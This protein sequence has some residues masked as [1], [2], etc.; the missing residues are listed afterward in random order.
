MAEEF[1]PYKA[2]GQPTQAQPKAPT[3]EFDPYKAY[4]KPS[5]EQKPAAQ[6]P[7]DTWED[8]KKSGIAG[9]IRGTAAL[10]GTPGDIAAGT[11]WL[12]EEARHRAIQSGEEKGYVPQGSAQEYRTQIEKER[13]APERSY[14]M[15]LPRS[16]VTT[17]KAEELFPEAKYTPKTTYGEFARTGAEFLPAAL[18]PIGE[19]GLASRLGMAGVSA[20]GSEAAG[21]FAKENAPSAEPYARFAGALITPYAASKTVGSVFNNLTNSEKVAFDTLVKQGASDVKTGRNATLL[22]EQIAQVVA[23]EKARGVPQS[24]SILRGADLLADSPSDLIKAHVVNVKNNPQTTEEAQRVIQGINDRSVASRNWVKDQLG[25]STQAQTENIVN[26]IRR[27]N[28]MPELVNP[29]FDEI[30]ETAKTIK[31]ARNAAN[32]QPLYQQHQN[33]INPDLLKVINSPSGME[34]AQSAA[35]RYYDSVVSSGGRPTNLFTI[36]KNQTTGLPQLLPENPSGMPMEFWHLFEQ[37][38]RRGGP[39]VI[40]GRLREQFQKGINNY[41]GS[42]NNQYTNAQKIASQG[43]GEKDAFTAGQD[44]FRNAKNLTDPVKRSE[45][46]KTFNSLTPQEKTLASAGQ[47]RSL[48]EIIETDGGRAQLSKM[49]KD[50]QISNTLKSLMDWNVPQGTPSNFNNLKNTMDIYNAINK[51]DR[52]DFLT[53]QPRTSGFLASHPIIGGGLTGAALEAYQFFNTL[54]FMSNPVAVAA[55]WAG[56]GGYNALKKVGDDKVAMQILKILDSRDPKMLSRLSEE[57]QQ[58]G[59]IRNS[60][61]NAVNFLNV[62]DKKVQE[63][64][65]KN[66]RGYSGAQARNIEREEQTPHKGGG[67]EVEGDNLPPQ[68]VTSEKTSRNQIPALFKSAHLQTFQNHRNVD[69]GGGKYDRGTNYL[70]NKRGIESHVYDPFNRSQEHNDAVL[71]KFRHEPAHS[72]TVA[73]VLNVIPERE[74]RMGAIRKAYELTHPEAKSYFQIYE[75]DKSGKGVITSDGWQNNLKTAH[76][77]DEINEVFPHIER[78]GNIIIAHKQKKAVGGP[79]SRAIPVI[80]QLTQPIMPKTHY[81]HGGIVIKSYH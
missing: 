9:G 75:G 70:A 1:D 80:K 47:A 6:P 57:I 78:K 51:V 43:F 74:H 25:S 48:Q 46:L 27:Q 20:L 64:Y 18:I 3:Q 71:S 73:N 12:W 37:E 30:R 35:S 56:V 10:L 66:A 77:L 17:Q 31:D 22:P 34:A 11:R 38:L 67:G 41:F 5:D 72:A 50:P 29:T 19:V 61:Q 45:F 28:G 40:T 52:A 15:G 53:R 62:T 65:M 21:Q 59:K 42:P 60:F 49:L 33:V 36:S 44:F 69:I 26:D 2:Y 55:T 79:V 68:S 63:M 81:N 24:A 32:Y 16:E 14:A 8:V 39:D 13:N 76:Y 23:D 4:A 7:V 58:S 54:Q